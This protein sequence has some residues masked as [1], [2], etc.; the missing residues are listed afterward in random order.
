VIGR[1]DADPSVNHSRTLLSFALPA[2]LSAFIVV[3]L[4]WVGNTVL[5]L[6]RGFDAVG[7]FAVGM[8]F[9]NA[10]AVLPSSATIQLVPTV[11]AMSVDSRDRIGSLTSRSVRTAATIFFPLFFGVALFSREV[12][13]LLYG[14]EYYD[15]NEAASLLVTACYYSAIA[16]IIT[17]AI[18]GQ[19]R[20]W[21]A[22]GLN[23]LWGAIFLI[24]VM[25]LVPS[26]GPTGLGAAFAASYIVHLT[27]TVV[28]SNSYL[29][30][31]VRR[32]SSVVML[33]AVMYLVGF[34]SVAGVVDSSVL[35]RGTLWA[36]GAASFVLVGRKEFAWA[37]RRLTGR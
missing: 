6:E 1:S 25:A 13:G 8:V 22:L 14:S 12:I 20:M 7:Y 16:A 17:A 32:V 23:L 27:N 36:V 24:L 26:Y 28:V 34:F 30:I 5:A 4:M 2:T 11:S 10:L 15:A 9:F 19:G 37:F 29:K 33:S 18:A 35:M 31:G 3:P 21:V